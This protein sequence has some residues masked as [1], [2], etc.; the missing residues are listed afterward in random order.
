MYCFLFLNGVQC[1]YYRLALIGKGTSKVTKIVTFAN[2]KGGSGKSTLCINIA[3][4]L[5]KLK[6]SVCVVDADPQQSTLD[7]IKN[8]KDPVL[9]LV[10]CNEFSD[11]DKIFELGYDF[12]LIDTQGSLNKELAS[13]LKISSLVLVPCRISRDDIVGQGWVQMFL[14][15][16]QDVGQNIPILAVLNGVN[17]RSHILSHIKQQLREDGT[18]VAG[19]TVSQRVCF[20]ET[21]VNKMSVI[22][23]NK[24]AE[25]EIRELT[26]EVL[27]FLRDR[28]Q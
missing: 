15:K 23:Y 28:S 3:A 8:T 17:K 16:S 5:V 25:D 22:S 2:V 13:F 7:W 18:S 26:C 6:Q 20:S 4:M 14:K 9:S 1:L 11:F 27:G 19:T 12:V 10:N 24:V 21:N